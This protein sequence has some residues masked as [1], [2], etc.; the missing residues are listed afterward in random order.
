MKKRFHT[1]RSLSRDQV[2]GHYHSHCG[3][4]GLR[5]TSSRPLSEGASELYRG[6]QTDWETAIHLPS[7]ITCIRCLR[8]YNRAVAINAKK[9]QE[10]RRGTS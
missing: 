1:L 8:G 3:L 4:S 5:D 2:T 9:T 7:E 10:A 6:N